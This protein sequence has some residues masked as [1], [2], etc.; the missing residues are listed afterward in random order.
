VRAPALVDLDFR[1]NLATIPGALPLLVSAFGSDDFQPEDVFAIEAGYRAQPLDALSLD[2]ALFYNFYDDLRSIE[3]GTPFLEATPA[4]AHLVLPVFLDNELRGRSYGFELAANLQAAENW[5]LSLGFSHLY[6]NLS[7]TSRSRADDPEVDED[8]TPRNQVWLRSSS[9]LPGNLS[10]D[11][12][13]RYVGRTPTLG[14]DSYAEADARL[15]WSNAD[16]SVEVALVGQ[17]LLHHEHEE[18]TADT[19]FRP[20]SAIQ[21]AFFVQ[22]IRRFQ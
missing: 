7:P 10:L 3:P 13:L 6:L 1:F 21:R 9:E 12:A 18:A 20:P 4:P 17:N 14:V 15:S 2:A 19:G 5:R 8:R 16:A 11:V 22:L